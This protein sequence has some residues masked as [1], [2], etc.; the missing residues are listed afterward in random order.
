MKKWKNRLGLIALALLICLSL[1]ACAA[2]LPE[3]FSQE[4]VSVRA[5]ETVSL[6][7]DRDYGAVVETFDATMKEALDEARLR[8]AFDGP[9][10]RLGAFAD[11]KS[12]ALAGKSDPKIGEYA[13]AVLVCSYENGTATY[14]IS[15]NAEGEVCGLFIK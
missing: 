1:G 8:E 4:D 13:V 15:I 9:L 5:R 10:D 3:G 11:F 7:N 6:L 2:A 12:E 14:T